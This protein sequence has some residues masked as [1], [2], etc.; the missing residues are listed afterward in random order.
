MILKVDADY[1]EGD[2]PFEVRNDE[3]FPW[4]EAQ[5]YRSQGRE[6]DEWDIPTEDVVRV[7]DKIRELNETHNVVMRYRWRN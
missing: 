7:E 3:L 2:G 6:D 5:G 4:L 1:R